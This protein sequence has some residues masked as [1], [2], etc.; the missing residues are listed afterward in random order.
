MVAVPTWLP[1]GRWPQFSVQIISSWEK[2]SPIQM[3]K[4]MFQMHP[5]Q[6]GPVPA[7]RAEVMDDSGAS[8]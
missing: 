6:C 8:L 1:A 4:A 3:S 5:V 2:P 7:N